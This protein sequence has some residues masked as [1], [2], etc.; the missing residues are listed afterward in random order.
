MIINI[1]DKNLIKN[2]HIF[3]QCIIKEILHSYLFPSSSS[4]IPI[5]RTNFFPP[6]FWKPTLNNSAFHSKMVKRV[7]R[8]LV[9]T[10]IIFSRNSWINE[11]WH[12]LRQNCASIVQ[13]ILQDSFFQ[14][15]LR[16]LTS[17]NTP[18]FH[19]GFIF[20]KKCLQLKFHDSRNS[21]KLYQEDREKLFDFFTSFSQFLT[22]SQQSF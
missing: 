1:W 16:G 18:R 17:D 19:R 10:R 22:S 3:F 9:A 6:F 12:K 8:Y 20:D 15:V 21:G 7:T 14:I 2:C 4:T 5:Y 11:K 13:K